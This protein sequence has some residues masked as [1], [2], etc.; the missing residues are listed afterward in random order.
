MQAALHQ[1]H[2]VSHS[3]TQDDVEA[4]KENHTS[5]LKAG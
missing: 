3:R 5:Q 2:P 1:A 4:S